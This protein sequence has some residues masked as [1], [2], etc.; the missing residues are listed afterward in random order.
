VRENVRG[1]RQLTLSKGPEW[2]GHSPPKKKEFLNKCVSEFIIGKMRAPLILNTC[3]YQIKE[4]SLSRLKINQ[5]S[6]IKTCVYSWYTS[7]HGSVQEYSSFLSKEQANADFFLTASKS[8][9]AIKKSP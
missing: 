8:T 6:R 9:I 3:V 7:P 2:M 5:A 1:T 4:S